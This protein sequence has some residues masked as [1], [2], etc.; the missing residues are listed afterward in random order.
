MKI[1]LNATIEDDKLTAYLLVP[2]ARNDKSKFLARAGYTL[3]N[4]KALH[5][6]LRLLAASTDAVQNRADEYGTFYH[7]EGSLNGVNGVDLAVTEVWL[8]QNDGHFKF[9][10]LVPRKEKE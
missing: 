2:K 8:E 1:P 4:P 5:A 6:A 3:Q 10:T 9:I 7:V